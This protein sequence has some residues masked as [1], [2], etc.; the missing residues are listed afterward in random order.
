[1]SL[2]ASHGPVAVAAAQD[3]AL[4]YGRN[5]VLRDVTF[6]VMPGERWFILGPNGAGKSTLVRAL[7]GL[8]PPLAGDIALARALEDRSR[9]GYVPQGLELARAVPTTAREFV[10]TGLTGLAVD[11][12][13]GAD[14]VMA[15]LHRVG[16]EPRA[17][18]ASLSGGQRQRAAI[19]RAL[20]R[21]PLLL[22][23]DEPATGLDIVAQ[24]DLLDLLTA[25][26]RDQGVTIMA[27]GHDLGQAQRHAT[28]IALVSHGGVQAGS[29]EELFTTTHLTKAFGRA[30][31]P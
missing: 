1:M 6:Q 27:V 15:A 8:I 21:D 7:L 4:G 19:A 9:L 24:Q 23:V 5:T 10:S 28:H 22:V 2:F 31:W 18:V 20:V 11:R 26:N 25:L 29:V 3:L 12:H 14:R 13:Q 17:D 16:V 30:V